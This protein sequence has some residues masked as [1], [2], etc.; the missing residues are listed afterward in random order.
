MVSLPLFETILEN[1]LVREGTS[2]LDLGCG[3]GYF[4]KM[5]AIRG[6]QVSGL[7][8]AA[9]LLA[10]ARE[11]VDQGD[12]RIGEMEELPYRNESF[13]VVTGLNSF[14]F[15]SSPV[16]ALHEAARVTQSGGTV[17]I[18]AFGKPQDSDV[19]AYIA[20]VGALLPP[21]P[22]GA[23][24]P[25]ALSSDG[26]LEALTTRAGL[27]PGDVVEVDSPWEYPDEKTMLRGMLSSGL[28]R[29][30]LHS[31]GEEVVRETV[32]KALAPFK[33]VTNGYRLRH[34]FRY[35]FAKTTPNIMGDLQ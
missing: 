4:C 2:L 8:A 17:V 24:G 33:T 16:N 27:I 11:R 6:A 15:T 30:A 9:P 1:G 5:A 31:L 22:S 23:S 12:F 26:M 25:F 14:Q 21:P 18:G 34:K 10:I 28:A 3:S 19:T 29:R 35:M 20:A 13:D 32:I 7:D